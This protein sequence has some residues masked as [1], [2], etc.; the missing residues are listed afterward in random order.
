MLRWIKCALTYDALFN[1]WL[2]PRPGLDH[3]T[4][5]S[6]NCAGLRIAEAKAKTRSGVDMLPPSIFT[7][8]KSSATRQAWT[9]PHFSDRPT[10][11]NFQKGVGRN[12]TLGGAVLVWQTESN[13]PSRSQ[14][15]V[16]KSLLLAR[17]EGLADDQREMNAFTDS[18]DM[19]CRLRK[20]CW[21]PNQKNG[22]SWPFARRNSLQR[23]TAQPH[24]LTRVVQQFSFGFRDSSLSP[25]RRPPDSALSI[26]RPCLE[27][28]CEYSSPAN[29]NLANFQPSRVRSQLSVR[30]RIAN[31][32]VSQQT[33]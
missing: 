31:H 7:L 13:T 16:R 10:K 32:T 28:R 15:S 1:A 33:A 9:E 29:G 8:F 26:R 2:K 25:N 12:F 27:P 19:H 17:S 18:A 11:A 4:F 3:R 24:H 30:P 23:L 22:A 21:R 6:D 14:S 20:N 5:V